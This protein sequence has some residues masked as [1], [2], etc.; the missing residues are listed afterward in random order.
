MEKSESMP[1]G[2]SV[3]FVFFRESDGSDASD[4]GSPSPCSPPSALGA[5]HKR[6]AKRRGGRQRVKKEGL[7]EGET[8]RK[9]KTRRN[10]DEKKAK[11]RK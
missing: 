11:R 3:G 5:Y 8:T 4:D 6:G 10:Q 7:Y 1:E 9:E 2:S